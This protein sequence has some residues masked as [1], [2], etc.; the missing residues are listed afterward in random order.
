MRELGIIVVPCPL[1]LKGHKFEK[2]SIT[3]GV[4]KQ[5][6]DLPTRELAF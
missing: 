6:S 3:K 5:A 4:Y 2:A 1:L